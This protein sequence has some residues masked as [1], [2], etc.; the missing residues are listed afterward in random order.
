[1]RNDKVVARDLPETLNELSKYLDG[2]LDGILAI[3]FPYLAAAFLHEKRKIGGHDNKSYILETFGVSE[4]DL[5]RAYRILYPKNPYHPMNKNRL[6][7]LNAED[8]KHYMPAIE[9][10]RTYNNLYPLYREG[11]LDLGWYSGELF[12]GRE[13]WEMYEQGIKKYVLL[14]RIPMMVGA[15]FNLI[16]AFV[17]SGI[18]RVSKRTGRDFVDIDH[19]EGF[20]E[21]IG[22]WTSIAQASYRLGIS[23]EQL[24]HDVRRAELKVVHYG[25]C[26][27]VRWHDVEKVFSQLPENSNSIMSPVRLRHILGVNSDEDLEELGAEYK[28][29]WNGLTFVTMESARK[30]VV[31]S[32]T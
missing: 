6:P 8:L 28:R 29:T 21:E 9:L 11:W 18:L 15:P 20:R 1:M 5:E 22:N 14:Q 32:N 24:R 4:S 23:R 13:S 30:M 31:A 7:R 17:D 12:I 3:T 26:H 19:I 27:L 10:D 2:N 16:K 25:N